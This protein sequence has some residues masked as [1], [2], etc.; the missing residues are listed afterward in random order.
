MPVIDVETGEEI[1][2]GHIPDYVVAGGGTRMKKFSGGESRYS[3]AI[4]WVLRST[5][6][7]RE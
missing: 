3:H 1:S 2:R 7:T 6:M 5:S 4:A